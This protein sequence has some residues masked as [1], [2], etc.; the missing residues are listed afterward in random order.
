M[1]TEAAQVQAQEA[2]Y[3]LT[4]CSRKADRNSATLTKEIAAQVEMR[5]RVE[6]SMKDEQ[7][8]MNRQQ[9]NLPVVR[10]NKA[11]NRWLYLQLG[12]QKRVAKQAAGMA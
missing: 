10:F 1:A 7:R 5:K 11:Y 3:Q 4:Q 12:E 8:E 6:K 9:R 2:T